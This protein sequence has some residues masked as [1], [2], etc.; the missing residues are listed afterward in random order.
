MIHSPSLPPLASLRCAVLYL[1]NTCSE[2]FAF[3]F[4]DLFI[5]IC[6]TDQCQSQHCRII[7]GAFRGLLAW[8][9][10]LS[11][12]Q[13]L[14]T[15]LYQNLLYSHS[16]TLLRY[17]H[18][19]TCSCRSKSNA[20]NPLL[21]SGGSQTSS[22]KMPSEKSTGFRSYSRYLNLHS[23]SAAPLYSCLTAKVVGFPHVRTGPLC[24]EFACSS[25]VCNGFLFHQKTC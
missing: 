21:V 8:R 17:C 22:I 11:R 25:C 3:H 6:L 23:V 24:G 5:C 4:V 9:L 1:Q 15:S 10:E 18:T 13:I 7:P 12:Y 19:S 14:C 2:L 20:S 16:C